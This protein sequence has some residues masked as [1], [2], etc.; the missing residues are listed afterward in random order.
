MDLRSRK[1][2]EQRLFQHLMVSARAAGLRLTPKQQAYLRSLVARLVKGT[3]H[4]EERGTEKRLMA[5]LDE[6]LAVLLEPRP[7]PA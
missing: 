4:P 6:G 7:V 1:E 3:K 2:L 5:R